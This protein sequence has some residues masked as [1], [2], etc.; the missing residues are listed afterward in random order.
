MFW[1][2]SLISGEVRDSFK[3]TK[4]SR[5]VRSVLI[6]ENANQFRTLICL[7]KGLQCIL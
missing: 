7:F 4:L 3:E 2:V 6:I 5:R 1:G